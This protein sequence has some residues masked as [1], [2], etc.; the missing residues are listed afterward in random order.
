MERYTL[1]EMLFGTR[2]RFEYRRCSTCGVL[3]LE[4]PPLDL[5][6]YYPR[7]YYPAR[8]SSHDV[9]NWLVRR[10]DEELA[11]RRLFGGHRIGAWI[12]RHL[13]RQL[14]PKVN[15]VRPMVRAARLRSLD[16]PILDVGSGPV[17]E[18]LW[19][20]ADAGF[21]NLLGIDPM[22]DTDIDGEIPVRRM[23]IHEL[24][25]SFALITFHHSFE[26]IADPAETLRSARRLLRPGGAMVIRTPVMGTW[27]WD[28]YG[29]DWWELDAPRHLFVHTP[30]SLELLAT[31]AGLALER[32]VYEST[33]IEILA[34]DQI[35]RD[36]A[37][38]EPASCWSDLAAPEIQPDIAAAKATVAR[39]NTEGRGGRANYLFRTSSA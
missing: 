17:P 36:I 9:P 1:R 2:D 26:H 4:S 11:A 28:T 6:P 19:Q 14:N 38:R 3:W 10:L 32:T 23:T 29:R 27:F 8:G 25:G 13:G 39:L 5:G 31:E 15:E 34:S 18:R 20:L 21:R 16:D 7:V 30:M 37:W 22:I 33:F 35:Q 24:E 12:A